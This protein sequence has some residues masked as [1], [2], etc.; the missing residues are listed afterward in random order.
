[1]GKRPFYKSHLTYSII[2]LAVFIGCVL[3][4]N[5]EFLFGNEKATSGVTYALAHVDHVDS[6]TIIPNS[7]SVKGL[8]G[9]SQELTVHILS[10]RYIGN[11]VHARN[12]LT[13]GVQV[14]AH[15]GQLLTVNIT[16][17][18]N[19]DSMVMVDNYFRL[20]I[21]LILIAA[22]IFI[23]LFIGRKKGFLSLLALIFNLVCVLLIFIPMVFQGYNPIF[24]A[25]LVAL[26]SSLA[27]FVLLC[28]WTGKALSAWI[29]TMAGVAIASV[30]A[31]ICN[32][33]SHLNGFSMD[34]ADSL[35]VIAQ[36][37]HM[38]LEY[39][40]FA[41]ILISSFGAVMDI[42]MSVVATMDELYRR[43]PHLS[44]HALFS[45]GFRV[46]RDMLGTMV[47]T[48][49]LAFVGTSVSVLL[50]LYTYLTPIHGAAGAQQY[51]EVLSQTSKIPL[52]QLL[53]TNSVG[54]QLL[55]GLIGGAAIMLTVPIVALVCSRLLPLFQKKAPLPFSTSKSPKELTPK[56]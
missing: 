28:G 11:T 49:L 43:N 45:S 20:P 26:I 53:N 42:A 10:G 4:F 27:T 34:D 30:I 23:L 51:P 25:L 32:A 52:L 41:G 15:T 50:L 36:K 29:S 24:A 19:G 47:N 38:H 40:L 54:I 44:A 17:S 12:I 2:L 31:T 22:F 18:S 33:L 13:T 46:G 37:T 35:I 48:L 7:D 1:M 21:W 56:R 14:I 6:Q 5:R 16:T 9:G 55:D 39:L 8:Y 3:F